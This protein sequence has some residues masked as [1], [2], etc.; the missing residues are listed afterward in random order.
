MIRTKDGVNAQV[1]TKKPGY[2]CP[3]AA[4]GLLILSGCNDRPDGVLSQSKMIDI[5]TDMQIAE[6]YSSSQYGIRRGSGDITSLGE[7]VLAY[8]GVSRE[9]FDSTLNWYGRNLDEYEKMYQEVDRN[10][11]KRQKALAKAVGDDLPEV[12]TDGDLWPYPRHFLFTDRDLSDQISFSF[13]VGELSPGDRIE[14]RMRPQNGRTLS[15]MLGAEY[16]DHTVQYTY[17]TVQGRPGRNTPTLQTD[18]ASRVVRLF[19]VARSVGGQPVNLRVDSVSL[20]SFPLDST[21]FARAGRQRRIK[22]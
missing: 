9:E 19:G 15:V 11:V 6:A 10:L 3:L 4:I 13:P 8:H 12:S 1:A 7:G 2:L 5:M 18:T 20:I 17:T 14:W 21:S 16:D 22:L